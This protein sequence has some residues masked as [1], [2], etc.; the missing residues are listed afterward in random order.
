MSLP[1]AYRPAVDRALQAAFGTT[2]MDSLAP[3]AGG[4]SGALTY[5]IRVGGIAYLLRVETQRDGF[6]DPHRWHPC[7]AIAAQ[8]CLAPRV[9]YADAT[10]G[11]V[12]MEFISEQSWAVDYAGTR[13]DLI[14]EAAQ[15]VRALHQTQAFPPLVDYMQGMDEV[16]SGFLATGLLAKAATADLLERYGRVRAAYRTDPADLVSSHNDLN[17]RNILYDGRRLWFIDW[18]SAFL[19]DR[20]VDLATLANFITH[21]VGEEDLL[22]ATYF[23]RAPDPRQRARHLVMRQVNHLFYG[24]IMLTAVARLRPGERAAGGLEGPS[25]A[26]IH[27]GIGA[28]TF[29]LE[30]WEG[31]VAYG[32]ARLAQALAGMKT[33][34]F[35]QAVSMLTA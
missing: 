26:E 19:A 20:H 27:Q 14:V 5:R 31:Q 4:L 34:A 18:E 29:V 21:D 9:R 8:A 35:D 23:G 2:E 10:D 22:L 7:M 33:D 32:R 15:G 28:G 11:V 1:Q 24:L 30:G 13:N 16:W 12:I 3:V 17:P 6:Q 25:L